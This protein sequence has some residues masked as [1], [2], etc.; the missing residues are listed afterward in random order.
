MKPENDNELITKK[1]EVKISE[2]KS[3]LHQITP[4]S[5]YLAMALF[6]ILPFLGAYIG[7]VN[8]PETV[9]EEVVVLE[10]SGEEIESVVVKND[11]SLELKKYT[12]RSY[13]NSE[14]WEVWLLEANEQNKYEKTLKL[15]D[16]YV[17]KIVARDGN[18]Y[19]ANGE[20]LVVVELSS[21][22]KEVYETQD[23]VEDLM[24]TKNGVYVQ[25][26]DEQICTDFPTTIGRCEGS[27]ALLDT[28]GN[29]E[30][31]ETDI[32]GAKGIVAYTPNESV[33]LRDGY[34][35]AGCTNTELVEYD[36]VTKATSTLYLDVFC[37]ESESAEENEKNYQIYKTGVATFVSSLAESEKY[38]ANL[39]T[40]SY[41]VWI[42]ENSI[43]KGK[44]K[45]YELPDTELQKAGADNIVLYTEE[46]EIVLD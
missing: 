18:L 46:V 45:D 31:V 16:G 20:F 15:T 8:A 28:D 27:L 26:V 29:F 14:A 13:K 42:Y 9:V 40:E 32:L 1:D 38:T 22:K 5:K 3:K 36:L 21:L 24:F 34:G 7:Y 2:Q 17:G 11:D 23:Y 39:N 33:V 12:I 10:S 30:I 37:Y 6:I 41:D 44:T 43:V 35:D 19:I 25:M 4:L